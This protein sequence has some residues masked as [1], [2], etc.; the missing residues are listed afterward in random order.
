MSTL[1]FDFPN[2]NDNSKQ[3]IKN[4]YSNKLNYSFQGK[5]IRVGKQTVNPTE[6]GGMK[7][8]C[9]HSMLYVENAQSID[10]GNYECRA[11]DHTNKSE[12]TSVFVRIHRK[13]SDFHQLMLT[14]IVC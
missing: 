6:I 9:S 5:R 13:Y 7:Y 12:S 4:N 8:K 2:F 10:Q 3:S 14:C 11:V 1:N